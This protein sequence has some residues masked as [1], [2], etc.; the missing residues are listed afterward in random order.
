MGHL[1]G[2]EVLYRELGKKIDGLTVRRYA[3]YNERFPETVSVEKSSDERHTAFYFF[4]RHASG[5]KMQGLKI[6]GM[7]D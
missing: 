5:V 1:A 2:K 6:P 3:R 4:E 7:T